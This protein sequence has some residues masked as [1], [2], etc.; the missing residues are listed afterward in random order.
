MDNTSDRNG[1]SFTNKEMWVR[2][3]GKLDV[4]MAKQG[5]Y[6]IELAMLK[7]RERENRDA[8]K[9][10]ESADLHGEEAIAKALESRNVEVDKKFEAYDAAFEASRTDSL[11]I[12]KKLAYA[13]GTVVGAMFLFNLFSSGLLDRL[14]N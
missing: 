12:Q 7:E 11:T 5:S 3:D 2:V 14:F 6:D 1:T 10:L 9:R 13:T 8:I 4:I